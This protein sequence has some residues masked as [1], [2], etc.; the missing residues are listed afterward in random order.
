MRETWYVLEDG[1][2]AAPADCTADKNGKLH[3]G[4]VAVAYRAPG[5]PRTSGVDP[6]KERAKGKDMKP[7]TQ[8]SGYKT[9]EAKAE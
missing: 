4:G 7:A 9:R 8:K 6:D 2:F 3:K 5:V 1:T